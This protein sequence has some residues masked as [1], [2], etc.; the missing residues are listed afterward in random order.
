M[1]DLQKGVFHTHPIYELWQFMTTDWHLDSSEHQHRLM[2]EKKFKFVF[3]LNTK[4]RSYNQMCVKDPFSQ[5]WSQILSIMPH[6]I[7]WNF[8]VSH[9][10]I[11]MFIPVIESI[12]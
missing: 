9:S 11:E 3:V 10:I 6:F 8:A 4:L 2:D 1:T 12:R 7:P 5:I